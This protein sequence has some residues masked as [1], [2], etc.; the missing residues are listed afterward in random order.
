MNFQT[1]MARIFTFMILLS[2]TAC[3]IMYLLCCLALLTLMWKGRLAGARRGTRSLAVVGVAATLYSLWT[4]IG[5]GREAALWAALLLIL[6][7]P[8]FVLSRASAAKSA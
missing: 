1:S 6:G 4:I 8:V 5:A 2:T 3:L 7:V